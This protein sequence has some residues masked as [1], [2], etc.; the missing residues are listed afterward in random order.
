MGAPLAGER[1]IVWFVLGFAVFGVVL[2]REPTPAAAQI[3]D[4]PS[5]GGEL[6][7]PQASPHSAGR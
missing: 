3:L 1:K 4:P 7:P 2:V 6:S 5:R